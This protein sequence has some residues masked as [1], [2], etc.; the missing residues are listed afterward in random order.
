MSQTQNRKYNIKDFVHSHHSSPSLLPSKLNMHRTVCNSS[1]I[2]YFFRFKSVCFSI[3]S[4][5]NIWDN[6][7]ASTNIFR[8][9]IWRR[10]S[11]VLFFKKWLTLAEFSEPTSRFDH[12]HQRNGNF[13][14]LTGLY[15]VLELWRGAWHK[16]TKA[17]VKKYTYLTHHFLPFWSYGTCIRKSASLVVCLFSSDNQ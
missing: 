5:V 12:R 8:T 1:D 3:F 7:K 11:S 10:R 16:A 6:S 17:F 14:H 4:G 2:I 13:Y 15:S 9:F